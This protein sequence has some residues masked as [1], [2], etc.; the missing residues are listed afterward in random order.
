MMVVIRPRLELARKHMQEALDSAKAL[1]TLEQ[2]N[3]LP[4]RIKAPRGLGGG[5]APSARRPTPPG[6]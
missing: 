4:D 3:Y 5:P 6:R 1:L 2:W